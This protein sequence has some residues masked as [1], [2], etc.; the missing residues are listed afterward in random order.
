[1]SATEPTAALR[2]LLVEDDEGDAFLVGELL[3]EADSIDLLVAAAGPGRGRGAGRGRR[4]RAARP[5]ACPTRR[6]WTA[7]A[8]AR[9]DPRRRGL[10]ADR[11]HRRAPRRRGGRRGRPGLPGQGPG[12][13]RAADPGASATRW[14]A[15][16]P[17]RTPAGCASASCAQAESA[18]LERGLL[19]QPLMAGSPV[20]RAH[21]LPARRH[22][23]LLGG[24][25][26]DV[27]PAR[28]ARCT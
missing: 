8:S 11:P 2:V 20:A 27:V 22:A 23:A 18:R 4:L 16:G 3:A 26:F 7:C 24:D 17:T 5:R 21:V 6:G 10:R 13:R 15:S 12:R 14:S 28:P 9:A 19:P 25:F 1:M